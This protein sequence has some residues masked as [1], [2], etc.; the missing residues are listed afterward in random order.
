VSDLPVTLLTADSPALGSVF[1]PVLWGIFDSYGNPVL[2][3]D[4]V[5]AVEYQ[6]DYDISTAPQEQGAFMS[7]NKVQNP[8]TAKVSLL[9]NRT[10]SYLL[11]VLEAATESL[12]LVSVYTPE[13]AYPSA[14]LTRYGLRRTVRNGVTLIQVDVW[15]EEVRVDAGTAYS[16]SQAGTNRPIGQ[17]APNANVAPGSSTGGAL[18]ASGGALTQGGGL[19]S[20]NQ[21]S[22][23]PASGAASLPQVPSYYSSTGPSV[24]PAAVTVQS[25]NGATPVTS[26]PVQASTLTTAPPGSSFPT[27]GLMVLVPQ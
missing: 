10:R 19:I 21:L 20:A 2:I 27:T 18:T 8:F 7:Y 3:S 17:L 6:R 25:T 15:V 4:S 13:V 12:Q 1:G 24:P 5:A 23:S 22:L 14:V 9:S 11:N 26:G 16:S